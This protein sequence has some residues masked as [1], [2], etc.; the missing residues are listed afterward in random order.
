MSVSL[1]KQITQLNTAHK[2]TV[3]VIALNST[4]L[5]QRCQNLF[6]QAPYQALPKTPV[7]Y[8]LPEATH[9]RSGANVP[10]P[11]GKK[12]LRIEPHLA[13]VFGQDTSRVCVTQAMHYVSGYLPVALYSLPHDS[14]Y[15]PDIEGRCQ[16]GFCVLGQEVLKSAVQNPAELT[17]NIAVNGSVKK[18]YVHLAMKHSIPELISFLSQFIA[19][20]A[21]DI[22]LTGTEDMP[23]LVGAGDQ[24]SVE[25][26]QL[27]CLT[28]TVT[29]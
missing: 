18:S 21:G 13:V 9:N 29:E 11:T 2:P 20:K 15:R 26:A 3:F 10:L 17:V 23:L 7:I 28:N 14:Y 5:L 19:F 22:L 16:E 12:Q 1:A 25:F 24:V 27:G 4:Q 8:V 6:E